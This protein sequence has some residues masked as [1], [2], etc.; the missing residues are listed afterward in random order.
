MSIESPTH[1]RRTDIIIVAAIVLLVLSIVVRFFLPWWDFISGDYC[2]FISPW[3][4]YIKEHG[5][6][7]ALSDSFHNYNPPYIYLLV[8]IVKSGVPQLAG[9]K[10]LSLLFEYLCF[11]FV[12]LTVTECLKPRRDAAALGLLAA[13][14][15]AFLPTPPLNSIWW[16][17]CDAIYAAFAFGAVYFLISSRPKTAI[18]FFAVAVSFK[19][20]AIFVFP[21]F[22]IYWLGRRFKFKYLAIGIAVYVV[23]MLPMIL[24]GRP[25]RDVFLTYLAQGYS[26]TECDYN[27][28]NWY[29]LLHKWY[30]TMESVYFIRFSFVTAIIVLTLGWWM[31][32]IKK[33]TLNPTN[34]VY[35][36]FYFM[37]LSPYLLPGMHDR[38]LF[39]A[40][41]FGIAFLFTHKR[42]WFFGI[43]PVIISLPL[44]LIYMTDYELLPSL[45]I[46]GLRA[47]G[48]IKLVIG[49]LYLA[50]VT[51]MTL[52]LRRLPSNKTK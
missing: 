14:A 43:A 49:S 29:V 3:C 28:A 34:S 11:A 44:Y 48:L 40:D 36:T 6:W 4:D 21:L 39:L 15:C 22:Y 27:F 8:L 16:S 30:P 19:L 38:Y 51:L 35:I 50:V 20:Q 18:V 17:Q 9:V 25:V 24:L 31:V 13:A 46:C 12:G 33:L 10:C 26:L 5:Y 1:H 23:L 42:F 7:N 41:I 52:G 47:P 37:M 45:N 32:K 2:G